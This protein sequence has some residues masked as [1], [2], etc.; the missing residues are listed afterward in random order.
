M[1]DHHEHVRRAWPLPD[2]WWEWLE[3]VFPP[4]KPPP[5]G[6]QRPRVADRQAMDAIVVVLRTG[7]QWNALHHPGICSSSAAHRRCQAWSAAGVC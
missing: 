7:C 6:W 5:L 1:R 4:R 2:E 3:P